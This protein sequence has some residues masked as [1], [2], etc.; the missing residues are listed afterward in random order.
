MVINNSPWLSQ[1]KR[2][3]PAAVLSDNTSADVAIIGGGIA[4]VSTAY[5][6][7][8]TTHLSVTLVEAYRIAHGATGHNAGQLIARFERPFYEL[9]EE[10]GLENAA[11]GQKAIESAWALLDEIYASAQLETPLSQ[12]TGYTALSTI[13]E[14]HAA[15]KNVA[16][17]VKGGLRPEHLLIVEGTDLSSLP[18]DYKSLYTILPSRDIQALLETNNKQYIAAVPER[19][20]CMNSALFC[21]ELV[22]YLLAK[23]PHRFTLAEH[24]PVKRL[25]L[26]EK[27]ALLHVESGPEKKLARD[28]T[29]E[30]KT[31]VLCTNG[32]EKLTIENTT[33]TEI[34]SKFHHLVNGVV[35]YMAGY[36]EELDKPSVGIAYYPP[37]SGHHDAFST[38]P[39]FYLTRRFYETE[40]KGR[41]NL[42]CV[43]G[44]ELLVEDSSVYTKNHEYSKEAEKDI[45]AFLRSSYIHA[46][47]GKIDYAFKWH[48]LMGY[49]PNGVRAIGP[50]PCNPVLYYNL[51]CNGIGLLPSIYG[52]KRVAKYLRG[53][54]IEATIFDPKDSRCEL[55]PLSK[56]ELSPKGV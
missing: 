25:V 43:G 3:R 51:G 26:Y 11:R 7:L 33:G 14:V 1:L 47:K 37:I 6:L 10:F 31:V 55:S 27:K 13:D 15:L 2:N 17:R 38:P 23:Y 21:E 42:I 35:G 40:W 9:V 50:E 56:P 44:P 54:E 49:T 8:T 24:S 41:H 28:H 36:L 20:G 5:Y 12:F 52:G 53:D 22:G 30:A 29:I 34:N 48:G 32:F 46:P 4:G 45:S 16:L 19:V 39:Y 18:Q